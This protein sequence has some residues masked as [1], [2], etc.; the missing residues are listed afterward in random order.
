M[1][2]YGKARCLNAKRNVPGT[3][4]PCPCCVPRNTKEKVFAKRARRAGK[5]EAADL[6]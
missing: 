6:S 5:A 1:K 2:T 4:R 3:N